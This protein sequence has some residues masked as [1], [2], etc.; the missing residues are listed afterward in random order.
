MSLLSTLLGNYA[1]DIT[2]AAAKTATKSAAKTAGKSAA[3]S[4]AN[5]VDDVARAAAKSNT[6]DDFARQAEAEFS[7]SMLP[8]ASSMIDDV[9]P[10]KNIAL[11]NAVKPNDF[12]KSFGKGLGDMLK[13][14]DADDILDL[15]KTSGLSSDSLGNLN[16][17]TRNALGLDFGD[18]GYNATGKSQL[19]KIKTSDYYKATGL[20]GKDVP[21]Y[22]RNH[23]SEANGLSLQDSAWSEL[24][25]KFSDGGQFVGDVNDILAMYEKA[26]DA[27]AKNIPLLDSEY[28]AN[29]FDLYPEA[30][31]AYEQEI[32]RNLG[33]GNKKIPVTKSGRTSS[34]K[35]NRLGEQIANG[36]DEVPVNIAGLGSESASNAT[37]AAKMVNTPS[38]E[39]KGLKKASKASATQ[40]LSSKQRNEY[41]NSFGNIT[42]NTRQELYGKYRGGGTIGDRLRKANVD[43]ANVADKS[44]QALEALGN[45]QRGLYDYADNA[46]V[47]VALGDVTKNSGLT[48]VQK[49]RIND[50]LGLDLDGAL[51]A[52]MT[53]SQAEELYRTLR[54]QASVLVNSSDAS[55][56]LVGKNLQKIAKEISN[57]IDE[58]IEPLK[59]SYG[60]AKKT[61]GA[62]QEYGDDPNI[63][64]EISKRGENFTV[65]DLRGEM[66]PW[67]IASEGLVGNKLPTED[68]LKIFGVDTG[69]PNPVKAATGAVRE[70]PLKTRAAFENSTA[71]QNAALVGA[72][73]VGGGILGSLLSG[74]GSGV[75]GMPMQSMYGGSALGSLTSG[76]DTNASTATIN[77]YTYDDLEQG[78]IA[79]LQAGDTDAAKII[80][81]MMSMLDEKLARQE[82]YGSSS[83]IATK[84]KA[85]INVLNNLMQN[86]KAK[87]TVGGNLTQFL[88][89]LSGG[90][91]DPQAYAYDTGS[92]GSMGSIIKA[93]GDT[94]ALSEGDQQRA[95][96]L[97]PSTTD[98]QAAAEQKYQQ[99]LQI[100]YST[101][102]K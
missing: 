44:S 35:V 52:E 2:K 4:L 21:S 31:E 32:A 99:L 88:N 90:G 54:N 80:Q 49:S 71:L 43:V 89:M 79:A 29:Y 91:Y 30:A 73:A 100:L 53:A 96:Q 75:S 97:L 36:A 10:A 50:I 68:T 67:M 1:D 28:Y 78:Y 85:A 15:I 101:G 46:G 8:K 7:K 76:A 17:E 47:T 64:R 18:L 60:L 34:I 59:S 19:P 20:R 57:K 69:A 102:T 65:A 81:N 45:V 61:V 6:L 42:R 26:D 58:S 13:G 55:Q 98:S 72:G 48:K 23:L 3:K 56:Q 39:L 93:L 95:L 74:G 5:K 33:L 41:A 92:R 77:G 38:D 87:G 84:Q 11:K 12:K 40:K 83:D 82:K 16:A 70:L 66:Q 25:P 62:M 86:F 24:I 51:S 94:G 63:I 22:M 37:K 27:L 14:D 9:V